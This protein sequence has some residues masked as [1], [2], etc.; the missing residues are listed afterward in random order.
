MGRTNPKV[1]LVKLLDDIQNGKNRHHLPLYL[2][3]E[4]WDICYNRRQTTI[5][6]EV[7]NICATYGYNVKTEGIGYR[8]S[9][10]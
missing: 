9:L 5:S 7:A 6:T 10:S 2:I 1:K 4:L 3:N 8:I